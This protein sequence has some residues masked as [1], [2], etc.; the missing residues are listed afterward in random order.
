MMLEIT[1]LRQHLVRLNIAVRP[2]VGVSYGMFAALGALL[3]LVPRTWRW[4]YGLI[5]LGIVASLL[6]FSLDFTNLGHAGA[7]L[8]G[9]A[10][11]WL[12][13]SAESRQ[14]SDP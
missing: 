13:Y 4:A 1:A 12:L 9:L 3:F 10:L 14:P 11:S 8:I 2:D 5:C 7:W 6:V